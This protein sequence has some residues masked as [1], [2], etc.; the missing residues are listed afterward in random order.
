MTCWWQTRRAKSCWPP[1]S[2]TREGAAGVVWHARE[3][4]GGAG[5]DRAPG[6]A[7]GRAAVGWGLRVLALIPT[8]SRRPA[9]GFGSRA[10]SPTGST[11][12]CCASLRALTAT[13][14]GRSSR[15]RSDQ[16][17]KGA[18][19]R[20]RGPRAR[21]GGADQP[22]ALRPRSALARPD[23][24][25]HKVD[26]A[27]SLAFLERTRARSTRKASESSA[28]RRPSHA[29]IT[30][31]PRNRAAARRAQRPEGRVG[32]AELNARRQLVLGRS[33]RSRR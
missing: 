1:R 8:R 23:R 18:H 17:A 14:S 24:P 28:S 20:A 31:A 2:R 13:G 5:R 7:V 25:V 10:A 4:Q 12:S 33:R 30:P 32:E 3:A 29:S 11:C 16:G 21:Q 27:I 6:R 22:V 19:T 9:R 15:I 26:S